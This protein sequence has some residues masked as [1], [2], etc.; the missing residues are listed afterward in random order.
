M[1]VAA[2]AG[3]VA[4]SVALLGYAAVTGIDALGGLVVLWLMDGRSHH[5]HLEL[6]GQHL[7]AASFVVLSLAVGAQA[8]RD[9]LGGQHPG[10]SAV[11]VVLSVAAILTMPPLA[12]AKRRLGERLR[13]WATISE[14][15]QS[16]IAAYL[17]AGLCLGLLANAAAG[18][19]WADPAAALLI[20][21]AA[22]YEAMRAWR[23]EGA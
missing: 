12:S 6:R 5:P 15:R 14:S 19:W 7:I 22:G 4:G 20:A 18:W 1:A 16:L 21:A 17:A 23:P 11:G 9:L 13:S 10:A 3:L 2:V 8:L